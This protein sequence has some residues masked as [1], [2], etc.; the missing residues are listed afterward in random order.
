MD[1]T[2]LLNRFYQQ[3]D[4]AALAD[5][6]KQHR[7]WALT[8]AAR[9]F[10]EEAEDAVQMS[11]IKLM[12]CEPNGDI[13]N[14]LGWWATLIDTTA[15]DLLRRK[16]R[17]RKLMDAQLAEPAPASDMQV[18]RDHLMSLVVDEID[19]LQ[20]EFKAAL[21]KR[22]FEDM[23]YR[24]ISDALNCTTGT[25]SSRLHRAIEQIRAGLRSRGV[26]LASMGD[27]DE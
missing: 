26:A 2:S 27:C 23:S 10:P 12:D 18:E 15:I 20:D 3:H 17:Q 21:L 11:I 9:I 6:V 22:F 24:E 19:T 1:A 16:I 8:R 14:P 7:E 4:D 13:R 25:V 5:F